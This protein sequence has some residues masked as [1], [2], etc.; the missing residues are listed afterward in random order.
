MPRTPP[1]EER[2]QPSKKSGG[3]RKGSKNKRTLERERLAHEAAKRLS[4]PDAQ[5]IR[6]HSKKIAVDH[7][8]EM[9]AY[10]RDLVAVLSPWNA[11]GTRRHDDDQLW[12]RV[13]AAY[14]GFL[15]MR[16]PYQSARLNAVAVYPQQA[17]QR[18]EVNVTILNEQGSQVYS[19]KDQGA[20]LPAPLDL[21]AV[22]VEA[23]VAEDEPVIPKPDDEAA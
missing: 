17:Q 7:M 6:R 23:A 18:T 13:V 10:F 22:A 20:P 14:Q 2:P 8:D 1:L 21:Q 5:P 3:R 16:A 12:L 4:A 19:D 15:S 9:I 11:D